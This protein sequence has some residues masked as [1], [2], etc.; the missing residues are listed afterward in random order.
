MPV[1]GHVDVTVTRRF[2][3][4]RVVFELPASTRPDVV[5]RLRTIIKRNMT[6]TERVLAS[7]DDLIGTV[8]ESGFE[9]RP[10]YGAFGSRNTPRISGDITADDGGV[11]VSLTVRAGALTWIAPP[12]VFGVILPLTLLDKLPQWLAIIAGVVAGSA[13]ALLLAAAETSRIQSLFT[14]ALSSPESPSVQGL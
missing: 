12:M 7:W 4:G 8:S 6:L 5:A 3:A 9:C 1:S 14:R 13:L 10:V 2:P 11:H